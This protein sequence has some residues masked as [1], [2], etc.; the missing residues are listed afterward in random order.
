MNWDNIIIK[1]TENIPE[2]KIIN[3]N[4]NQNEKKINLLEYLMD[5]IKDEL[6]K[7]SEENIIKLYYLLYLFSNMDDNYKNLNVI[8]QS[9]YKNYKLNDIENLFFKIKKIYKIDKYQI[10]IKKI[11]Y[12]ITDH[13]PVIF[14]INNKKILS[15]N[16]RKESEYYKIY[17]INKENIFNYQENYNFVNIYIYIIIELYIKIF[18]I[19]IICLQES[20]IVLKKLFENKY[21]I[22]HNYKENNCIKNNCSCNYGNC[23]FSG[24]LITIIINKDINI[25]VENIC[26]KNINNTINYC[27]Y[28]KILYDNNII[29]NLHNTNKD[30]Y[31]N[32]SDIFKKIKEIIEEKDNIDKDIYFIGDFNMQDNISS[33]KLSNNSIK[34]IIGINDIIKKLDNN[35]IYN[36]YNINNDYRYINKNNNIIINKIDKLLFYKKN[37]FNINIINNIL[38]FDKHYINIKEI[39]IN[40]NNNLTIYNNLF[41]IIYNYYDKD[42]KKIFLNDINIYFKYLLYI[43]CQY[44]YIENKNYRLLYDEDINNNDINYEEEYNKHENDIKNIIEYYDIIYN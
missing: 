20:S 42:E 32:N 31:I 25:N 17:S 38:Y 2:K 35:S 23:I 11:I 44:V 34:N 41:R 33:V 39:N 40:N 1:K 22:Y 28:M 13:H 18:N 6:K 3:N 4:N 26:N 19:D 9:N 24:G 37:Y 7:N 8:N 30:E 43:T 5:N 27:T 36:I 16:V 10:D 29:I 21:N 15:W 14:Y 12:Y